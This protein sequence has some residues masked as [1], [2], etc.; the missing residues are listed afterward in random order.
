MLP[1]PARISSSRG[2]WGST[3]CDATSSRWRRAGWS[4]LSD[5]ISKKH[6]RPGGMALSEWTCSVSAVRGTPV[7][8]YST[9]SF[10]A[11]HRVAYR[12]PIAVSPCL[13]ALLVTYF[14]QTLWRCG[15][16]WPY[17]GMGS[18]VSHLHRDCNGWRFEN[19]SLRSFYIK[20]EEHRKVRRYDTT[21]PWGSTQ[22]RG[23][24][25]SRTERVRPTVGK[26]RV[27]IFIA[28]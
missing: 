7:A 9:P 12:P 5:C 3:R 18:L 1:L 2:W 16:L 20:L 10:N 6:F 14:K 27:W 23:S 11:T 28:W 19:L 4:C 8:G 17:V 25:K 13:L 21:R 24:T 15:Q 22:L 26:D